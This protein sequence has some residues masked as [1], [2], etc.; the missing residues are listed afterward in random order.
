MHKKVKQAL[1]LSLRNLFEQLAW[2]TSPAAVRV[3]NISNYCG[4]LDNEKAIFELAHISQESLVFLSRCHQASQRCIGACK[5]ASKRLKAS[6][7]S[8]AQRACSACFVPV[9]QKMQINR[10]FTLSRN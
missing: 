4:H 8:Y 5:Y 9:L 1:G 7:A 3:Y 6:C 10:L 2:R